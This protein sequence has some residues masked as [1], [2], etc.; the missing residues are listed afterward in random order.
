M[1]LDARTLADAR[2]AIRKLVRDHLFDPNVACVDLGLRDGVVHASTCDHFDLR[3]RVHVHRKLPRP[4]LRRAV[5]AGATRP[6]P[7]TVD[8]FLVEVRQVTSKSLRCGELSLEQP[9]GG[10]VSRS[11]CL[12]LGMRVVSSGGAS[13]PTGGRITGIEGVARIGDAQLDRIVRGVVTID[14]AETGAAPSGEAPLFWLD[15]ATNQPVGLRL[16]GGDPPERVL[17]AEAGSFTRG[18][19]LR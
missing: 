4:A 15:A 18:W 7:K 11:W 13:E 9:R 8:D 3:V 1:L 12:R 19:Q 16:A 6:I 10:P 14:P 17:A 2:R 5:A